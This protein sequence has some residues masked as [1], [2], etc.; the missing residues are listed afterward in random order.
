MLRAEDGGAILVG[1]MRAR[2]VSRFDRELRL[3]RSAQVPGMPLLLLDADGDRVTAVWMR[4]EMTDRQPRPEPT[5]GVLD[6]ATGDA[7]ELFS[8]FDPTTGITRP[9]E[10]NPFAPPFLSA[11]RREDGRIVAGQSMEYRIALLDTSGASLA[12]FGREFEPVFLSDEERA[13]ER[14][15]ISRAARGARPPPA[16][17]RL[18]EESLEAPRPYFGPNAFNLDAEGR[19][20]VISERTRGDSTEVDLFDRDGVYLQTLLLRDRVQALA[21]RGP[22]LAALVERMAPDVE[23]VSGIDVFRLINAGG[24]RE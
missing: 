18:M 22:R 19:L 8:L 16:M 17:G 12:S 24:E 4:F 14:E 1:D 11:V 3:V 23:G 21:F 2:R 6:L 5:V 9:A 20:W 13:A 7:R 10:E 15:R